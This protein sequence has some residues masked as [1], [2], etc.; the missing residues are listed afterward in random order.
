MALTSEERAIKRILDRAA[1]DAVLNFVVRDGEPG[2]PRQVIVELEADITHFV[3][4]A[5]RIAVDL[6]NLGGYVVVFGTP[7]INL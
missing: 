2:E 1:P 5:R 7:S 3:H 4:A 6:S